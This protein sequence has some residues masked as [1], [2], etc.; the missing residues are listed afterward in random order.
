[1]SHPDR[2]SPRDYNKDNIYEVELNISTSDP[3]IWT[4]D[5]LKIQIEDVEYSYEISQDQ[6]IKVPE[7]QLFVMDIDV[8]DPENLY[9]YPDLLISNEGGTFYL[10]SSYEDSSSEAHFSSQS[11][12]PV[13]DNSITSFSTSA[14]FNND[15][16]ADVLCISESGAKIFYN[17]GFGTFPEQFNLDF[18]DYTD[19]VSLPKHGVVEDFDQDGDE[20]VV[21]AYYSFNGQGP[22]E[23]Y[24][25]ENLINED[26]NFTNG[27][28][29]GSD[30]L[31]PR[32]LQS[33][34]I[35]GDYNLDLV[36]ADFAKDE[37]VWLSNNGSAHFSFGGIIV[38]K[39]DGLLEPR[40]LKSV[41]LDQVNLSLD[42][43]AYTSQT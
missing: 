30:W 34:D 32:Y 36:V 4:L 1:M 18:S 13:G 41:D 42:Q 8:Q 9:Y 33:M 12:F 31:E 22:A 28:L 17:R 39:E 16:S 6:I 3:T 25:F 27:R 2:E 5:L 19:T 43:G 23:V 26:A 29:L 35:D 20:D 11:T 14:D 21:L 7:N 40:S 15:G 37:V 38:A 24:Y 10:A